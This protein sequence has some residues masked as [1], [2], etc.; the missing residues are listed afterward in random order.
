MD[1][2][3]SLF[4]QYCVA[5]I[6]QD[7]DKIVEFFQFPVSFHMSDGQHHFFQT[8]KEFSNY[9]QELIDTYGQLG[10][11]AIHCSTKPIVKVTPKMTL[12]E[13]TW[14]FFRGDLQIHSS[15]TKYLI[16]NLAAKPKLVNVFVLDDSA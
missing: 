1:K 9:N 2:V 14:Q 15:Q 4:N 10:I 5:L 3:Q 13:V 16:K 6:T 8:P 7:I 12:I 11:D